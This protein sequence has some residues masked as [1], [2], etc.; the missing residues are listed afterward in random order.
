MALKKGIL[1]KLFQCLKDLTGSIALNLGP[2]FKSGIL[3]IT[4]KI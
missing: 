3:L 2:T 1:H 4:K